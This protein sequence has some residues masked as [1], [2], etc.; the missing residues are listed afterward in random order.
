M[1]TG[2][3]EELGTIRE[4]VP[5][6]GG[7]FL[8]IECKTVLEGLERG[9]SIAVNGPCLTAVEITSSGFAAEL[10]PETVSRSTL[11]ELPVGSRVNLERSLRLSDRL[12]GHLVSGHIDGTGVVRNVRRMQDFWEIEYGAPPEILRYVV[13]KGSVAVDGVSLTVAGV[14]DESFTVAVIPETLRRTSLG[15]YEPGRTVNLE[16]DI[17]A[18]YVER[19]TLQGKKTGGGVTLDHLREY[20]YVEKE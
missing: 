11:A 4:S 7:R 8:R 2:I 9:G 15:S 1:F 6:G 19:F 5:R 14:G 20:G 18:K 3:I 13:E 12:E 16:A 17:I 10:S